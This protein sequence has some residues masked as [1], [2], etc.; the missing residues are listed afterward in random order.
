MNPVNIRETSFDELELPDVI[1]KYRSWTNPYH[2]QII[3]NKVLYMSSPSEFN[4]PHD[5]K[6]AVRYDS[7]TDKDIFSIYLYYSKKDHKDWSR[8]RH[9]SFAREWVRQTPLRDPAYILEMQQEYFNDFHSHFG[10]LSLTANP[11]NDQMWTSYSDDH[12][13]FCIGFNTKMLFEYLGGGG[14]VNYYDTLPIILPAPLH[15]Y[16]QQH[17]LQ[18]F[19]KLRQWEYEQEYRTHKFYPTG[20]TPN[21]RLIS[22]PPQAFKEIIFGNRMPDAIKEQILLTIPDDLG[23]LLL[24]E[25]NSPNS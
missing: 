15:S 8:E 11:Y 13:G 4:D 25:E 16:E 9:R 2:L 18:V 7:L 14:V 22:V 24:K 10:V 19:S 5:C 21:Q 20:A 17:I 1:Y 3:T 12:Q 23:H 6:N